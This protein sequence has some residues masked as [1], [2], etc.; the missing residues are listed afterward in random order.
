MRLAPIEIGNHQPAAWIQHPVKLL[1][2]NF[3]FHQRQAAFTKDTLPGLIGI[4]KL[5]SP[6][7]P[8]GYLR[9]KAS[10]PFQ[11]QSRGIEPLGLQAEIPLQIGYAGTR[12][13]SHIQKP[14]SRLQTAK[15]HQASG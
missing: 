13:A 12:T 3:Q 6:A 8:Q 14:V 11:K 7:L 15:F 9:V 4:R 1:P 10:P 5:F 2:G